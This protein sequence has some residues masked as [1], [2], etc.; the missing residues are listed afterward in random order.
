[1]VLL[2]LF[3]D[4]LTPISRLSEYMQGD[5]TNLLQTQAALE[6]TLETLQRTKAEKYSE[7]LI[8]IVAIANEAL[9]IDNKSMEFHTVN[10]GDLKDGLTVL[11]SVR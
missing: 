2:E 7:P 6:A 1:V 11:K 9:S 8:N 10:I 5:A 3:V 4:V